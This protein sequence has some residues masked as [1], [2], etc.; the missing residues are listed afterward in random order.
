ML[1][2]SGTAMGQS[3]IPNGGFEMYRSCPRQ[4]NLLEEAVPWYNPNR[5]TPDFYNECFPTNQI[6]LPPRTGA[7]L[8]RLFLDQGW[9]EYLATPLTK[10][11]Q[12]GKCYY[13]EMYISTRTPNQY[14]PKTLG[15]FFSSQPITS[16]AK[17]L[18]VARPQI[19]DTQTKTITGPYKWD[20]ISGTIKAVGG[21][22]FVTIGSF[23]TLPGFLGFYYVFIDDVSLL[24]IDLDLGNDT[25]LCGRKST[26]LLKA[27]TPGAIDYKWND[28]SIAPTLL[29]TKP[30]KYWVTVTTAC[31]TLRDTITVDYA[32]DFA[33]GADTTLCNGQSLRLMG[34]PDAPN[35]RWQDGSAQPDFMVSQPGKYSLQIRQGGCVVADT[36]QVNYIKPPQLE[37]GPNKALCGDDVYIIRPVVAEGIFA[38][39]DAFPQPDRTVNH[40]GTYLATVRNACATVRD[41]VDIDYG[42]CGCIVYAPDVFT[43]NA[44]GLNDLFQPV[45]CGDITVQSLS[46]FNRWGELIFQTATVPF[47]WDGFAKGAI[48]MPGVYV[49][50]IDYVLQ[51]RGKTSQKQTQGRL[52]VAY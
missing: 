17:D 41:S 26:Y 39:Q 4:D 9:A 14:V 30:G 16:T 40:S 48:C 49:W 47:Q 43:P 32:L 1:A 18:L 7:G 44:D 11:L 28:G 51:Q 24:P 8:A 37:L 38:W 45:A 20:R 13:F 19:L 2:V 42:E 29:V 52:V 46:I 36:I 10:P 22:R 6:E 27:T 15:A 21:E 25:T 50:H 23:N 5:A 34:P 33:L 12:A 3:L 31:N 35:Y